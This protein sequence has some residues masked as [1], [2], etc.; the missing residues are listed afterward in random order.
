MITQTSARSR[1]SG[2][3]DLAWM[4]GHREISAVIIGRLSDR[5]RCMAGGAQAPRGAVGPHDV[6]VREA[7][8]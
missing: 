4:H 6:Y 5:A 1:E 7:R 8:P 3:D 2:E